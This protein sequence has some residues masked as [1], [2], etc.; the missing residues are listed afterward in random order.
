MTPLSSSTAGIAPRDGLSAVQGDTAAPLSDRTLYG[1]LADAAERCPER[2]AVVVRE[3]AVRW[4]WREVRA[5]V[6][7]CANGL[8]LLKGTTSK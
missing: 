8:H 2:P 3:Q 4:N 1:L 6:D 7:G 5:A